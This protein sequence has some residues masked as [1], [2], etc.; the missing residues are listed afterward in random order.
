M[1]VSETSFPRGGVVK[2]D[3]PTE[4]KIVSKLTHF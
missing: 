2:K 3:V 4:P 1:V